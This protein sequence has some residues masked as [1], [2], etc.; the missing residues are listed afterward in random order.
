M[1]PMFRLVSDTIDR[2]S[3]EVLHAHPSEGGVGVQS[4]EGKEEE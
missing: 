1:G 4:V 3:F 2:T